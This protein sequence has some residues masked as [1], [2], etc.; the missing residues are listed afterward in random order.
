[1]IAKEAPV[2][3]CE[4]IAEVYDDEVPFLCICEKVVENIRLTKDDE[5][6]L[7]EIL[8]AIDLIK[9]P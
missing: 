7:E 3:I 1:M 5:K 8:A 9:K 6:K 2:K 4:K